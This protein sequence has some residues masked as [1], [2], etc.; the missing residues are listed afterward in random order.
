MSRHSPL[1]LDVT[2]PNRA[3]VDNYLLGGKDNFAADRH[4][5]DA[6]IHA[7]PGMRWMAVENRHFLHRA[8]RDLVDQEGIHQFLTIGT[9]FP[10]PPNLHEVAQHHAPHARF[11]YVDDDPIVMSH[12]RALMISGPA[13][14]CTCITADPHDPTALLHHPDL[15]HAL[16]LTTPVALTLTTLAHLPDSSD[17]W[18]L[19][20]RLRAAL[21]SGSC[22][23]I[24]HLTADFDLTAVAAAVAAAT[25]AGTTLVPRT[26]PAIALFFGNWDLLDPGL[27]PVAVWRPDQ[28]VDDPQAAYYWAGVARKP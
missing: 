12:A 2:G 24:T 28:P 11:V 6:L 7:I 1:P 19:T 5:G 27:V 18:T 3:R 8:T 23:A 25:A 15:H 21:P 22:L 26:Q 14:S 10:L 16:D 13:G 20:G 17:P 9:G 4:L